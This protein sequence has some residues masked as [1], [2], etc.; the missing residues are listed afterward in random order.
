LFVI[1]LIQSIFYRRT[2]NLLAEK[3]GE[4]NFKTAGLLMLIGGALTIILVGSFVFFIGWFFALAGFFS[5]KPSEKPIFT[6]STPTPQLS[7]AAQ[8][9]YCP[10]CGAEQEIDALFCSRCGKKL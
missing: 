2:F 7:T 9:R 8:K 6:A 5:M 1:I 3:S 4:G 10:F